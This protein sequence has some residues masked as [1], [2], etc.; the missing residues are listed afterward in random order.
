[1]GAG[2]GLDARP[3]AGR[4]CAV[5]VG[6]LLMAALTAGFLAFVFG[7][8]PV[9]EPVGPEGAEL[10]LDTGNAAL[11][12]SYGL[13]TKDDVMNFHLGGRWGY[14]QVTELGDELCAYDELP[15]AAGAWDEL[16][17]VDASNP[18][19]AY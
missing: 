17:G 6:V 2:W 15:G 11:M 3:G 19:F 16:Y 5:A 18:A 4:G 14:Y 12:H 9:E 8:A 13:P 10:V 7:D 1:M